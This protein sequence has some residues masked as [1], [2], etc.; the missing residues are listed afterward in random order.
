MCVWP[1]A[2]DVPDPMGNLR[3]LWAYRAFI[4]SSVGREFHVRYKRSLLGATWAVLNPLALIAVYTLIFSQ[5]MRAKLPGIEGMFA[6]S[7]YLCAGL[8]TW[9]FFS[10]ICIR[11]QNLFLDNAALLKKVSFPRLVLPVVALASACI[12]FAIV[13]GLFSVFMLLSGT[14]PGMV[15]I[16]VIPVL[17]V[18]VVLAQGLGLTLG[19]LNVFFRDVGQAFGIAL[20]FWFWLTPI[21]YPVSILPERL[22]PLL[23]LNPLYAVMNA[24]QTILARGVWP[25]WVALCY[26]AALGLGLCVVGW[27]LYRRRAGDIADEL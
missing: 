23:Q 22:Q 6:Y 4:G 9:G 13:F 14:F 16:A 27:C 3:A 7:I 19:V 10:E 2:T 17:A 11:G 1:T 20:Q 5:V 26:P 8:L 21:V 24:M 18:A 12:N 15:Y 25:D